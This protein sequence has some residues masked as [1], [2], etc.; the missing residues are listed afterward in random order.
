MATTVAQM[1][2]WDR[3]PTHDVYVEMM[4]AYEDDY[5]NICNL[6]TIGYSENGYPLLVVRDRK[7]VV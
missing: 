7:S 4:Q 6:D 1:S 5:P 2:D 3:Y